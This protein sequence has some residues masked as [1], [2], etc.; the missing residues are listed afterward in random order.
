MNKIEYD[1]FVEIIKKYDK[2]NISDLKKLYTNY[3]KGKVDNFFDRYCSSLS[4]EDSIK[5]I[6]KFFVYFE[7]L[8]S[9]ND[10][11]FNMDTTDTVGMMLNKNSGE[12]L[13]LEE[14]IEFGKILKEGREKLTIILSSKTNNSNRK[15]FVLRNMEEIDDDEILYP[16]IDIFKIIYSISEEE[17]LNKLKD[18][19]HLPFV[20]HDDNI[21]K[22]EIPVIKKYLKLCSNG[23]INEEMLKESFEN[24][25]FDNIKKL[26]NEELLY[27]LDLLKK[28]IIAKY[29]FSIRNLGLVNKFSKKIFD[30]KYSYED[31]MQDGYIGLIKAINRFDIDKGYRFS[32]YA[33]CWIQQNVRRTMDNTSDI[34]RKPV[35]IIDDLEKLRKFI[36]DYNSLNGCEPS[37]DECARGLKISKERAVELTTLAMGPLSLD[38]TY[39]D[40]DEEIS[41]LTFIPNG[42]PLIEETITRQD[43]YDRIIE[44]INSFSEMESYILFNRLGINEENR[45][46][47]LEE[48]GKK[49]NVTRERIRQREEKALKKL[50][51]RV[52]LM[53]NVCVKK[54][55][56]I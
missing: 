21:F 52:N 6:E 17:A 42:E 46:Y 2:F 26:S 8:T 16:D 28:Y 23:I 4:E 47:T 48:I 33:I 31:R 51:R 44:I 41:M 38:I 14:E 29:N 50:R 7:S 5:F 49:Y 43:Y 19:K 12:L 54:D 27:Q 18:L 53:D 9:V 20:L 25:D 30:G 3:G 24:I 13:T 36:N 10:N 45:I 22:K 55:R 40:E 37:I 56:N 39:N 35:H 34:I 32:T 1:K 15:R 11:K